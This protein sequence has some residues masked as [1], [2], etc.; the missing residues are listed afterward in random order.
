M[1]ENWAV[2]NPENLAR[3]SLVPET[4]KDYYRET[5]KKGER[6]FLYYGVPHI[7]YKGTLDVTGL[8]I[9]TP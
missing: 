8:P 5:I 7:I 6:P 3:F 2:Y 4:T 1:K 9:V